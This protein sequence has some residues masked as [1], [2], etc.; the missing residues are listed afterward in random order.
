MA[1]GRSSVGVKQAMKLIGIEDAAKRLAGASRIMVIGCSGSG[2]STISATLADRL[3]LRHVSMDKEF[4]WLP[5][6]VPRSHSE[7]ARL[8]AEA[9]AEERWIM[10]GNNPRNMPM[11]LPRTEMI[12]W[13][14]PTR[15]ASLYGVYG[16]ALRSHGKVRPDMAEGCPEQLPDRAFLRYIWNF[17]RIDA[18]RICG[19]I[20]A[21]GPDVPVLELRSRRETARLLRLLATVPVRKAA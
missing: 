1:P 19:I 3:G 2:K 16:R 8:M 17:E 12:I 18:P 15:W 14:R 5:G 7:V 4:F 20:A 11:R 6:W 13:M 10:D 9:V 21:H